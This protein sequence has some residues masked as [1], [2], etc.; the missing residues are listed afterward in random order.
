MIDWGLKQTFADKNSTFVGAL[1]ARALG[2]WNK[3]ATDTACH[4][5]PGT[6]GRGNPCESFYPLE[7]CRAAARA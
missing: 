3:R 1:P 2:F 6:A 7:A 4:C 5:E